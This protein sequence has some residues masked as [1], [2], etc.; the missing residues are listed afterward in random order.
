MAG[1]LIWTTTTT[2]RELGYSVQVGERLRSIRKQKRLSLHDVEAQSDQEFKA[3]VLGAYERG[4][5]A[6]SLPRLDRLAQFYRVPVDQLLPRG[7]DDPAR[8]RRDGRRSAP[9]AG[10]RHPQADPAVGRAVRDAD[11]VPADDPGPAPGLQRPRAHDPPA[12]TSGR[13]RRCSTSRSIRCAQR[14]EALDL[15][16]RADLTAPGSTGGMTAVPSSSRSASTCTSRSAASK[17]DYCAF[18]TWTDRHHLIDAVPRRPGRPTSARRRRRHAAGDEHLRRRRHAVA[19]RRRSAGGRAADDP[20]VRRVGAEV[21]VECNPDDVTRRTARPRTSPAG[22]TG[23]ASACSRWSSHVLGSLGRTHDR[24]NVETVGRGDPG[25]RRCRRSTSTSSTARPASRSPTGPT[26]VRVVL[27]LDPPHVSAYAL[28]IEAG[29]P[30]AAATRPPSRRRRPGRQVRARRRALRRRRARELRDLELGPARPRVPAQP[31]V[32]APAGLPRVRLRRP[33]ASGRPALVERAHARPLH[34][35]RR[36]RPADRGGRRD[37]RRRRPAGSRGCSCSCGC[38]TACRSTPSTAR[39]SPAWSSASAT[40]GCSPVRPPAGQR[41]H[42]AAALTRPVASPRTRSPVRRRV[43]A[44]WTSK[45]EQVG[46]DLGDL[47]GEVVAVRAGPERD[48]GAVPASV[49]VVGGR[50]PVERQRHD[51]GVPRRVEEVR[52][53]QPAAAADGCARGA[54]VLRYRPSVSRSSMSPMLHTSTSGSAGTSSHRRSGVRTCSPPSSSWASSVS[55][56]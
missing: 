20:D 10:D 5:R 47:G 48:A 51:L 52:E 19:G 34:R 6:L 3:S 42:P 54:G 44:A 4:E 31:P 32:L 13:S 8:G 56:P 18:A 12:T 27:A 41:R 40:A 23:S 50:R 37:A 29:T 25:G 35:A 9:E 2:T 39:S 24:R 53:R 38:A 16:F 7:A 36:R 28:T 45:G 22:S 43:D 30:L 33:L 15:V 17:C 49:G 1:E 26:T 55:S 21:T 14:L 46:E 11:P